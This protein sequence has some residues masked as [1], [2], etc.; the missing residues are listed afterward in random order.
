V[1]IA[2]GT[3]Q[4][5]IREA[6]RRRLETL[7]LQS[8]VH[9]IDTPPHI[10]NEIED[11]RVMLGEH[12]ADIDPVTDDNRYQAL[13]RATLLLSSEVAD[14]RGRVDR[15]LWL[16]PVIIIVERLLSWLV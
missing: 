7:E 2:F 4:D 5:R 1:A 3:H 16:I 14:L 12:A 9:G 8:A 10:A 15:L 13:F 6:Q 11:L